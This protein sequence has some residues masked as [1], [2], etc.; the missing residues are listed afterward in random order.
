MGSIAEYKVNESSHPAILT[1]TSQT[2]VGA[3]CTPP[4]PPPPPP[5]LMHN[6]SS[7]AR[8]FGERAKKMRPEIACSRHA[9]DGGK[10]R[11]HHDWDDDD[12]D[13]NHDRQFGGP[14]TRRQKR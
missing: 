1:H 3:K 13:H 4:P 10:G 5:V 14:V 11:T 6:C 7:D 2:G 9:G 8:D 12:D